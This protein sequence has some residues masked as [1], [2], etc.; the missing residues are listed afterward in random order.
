MNA[1]S[2]R[3]KGRDTL[4]CAAGRRLLPV[5]RSVGPDHPGCE[6]RSSG[7]WG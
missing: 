5:I 4:N 1:F 2:F 6:L 3:V 7:L